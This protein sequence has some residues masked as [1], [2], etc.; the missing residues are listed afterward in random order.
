VYDEEK[1]KTANGYNALAV[2]L[3]NRS[4]GVKTFS[5]KGLAALLP[6]LESGVETA[7][8]DPFMHYINTGYISDPKIATLAKLIYVTSFDFVAVGKPH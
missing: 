1:S 4:N 5:V 3:E 7:Q 2:I 8:N 6:G